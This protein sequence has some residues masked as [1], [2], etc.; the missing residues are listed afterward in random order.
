MIGLQRSVVEELLK[1]VKTSSIEGLRELLGKD[2]QG[3]QDIE[4]ILALGKNF[5]SC[6]PLQSYLTRF[7]IAESYGFRDWLVFDASVVRGLAYYTGVV[8]E[9]FD[10]SGQLRAI[11]GGGRYDKL[12]ESLGGESIPAVGFGFGDAVIVELLKMKNLLPDT[13]KN[14]VDSLVFASSVELQPI[15]SQVACELRAAG[16]KVDLVL[17]S[18]KTKWAFQRADKI[19]AKAVVMIAEDEW[20]NRKLIV[21]NLY[22]S[23]EAEKQTIC[24]V[25]EVSSVV[26]CIISKYV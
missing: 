22:T 14:E 4:R 21:K 7:S 1:C 12:L 15:A 3:L 20:K 19:G 13:S 23:D 6:L 24:A 16:V 10:R 17:E 2:T 11:C 8:F 5:L 9:G 18:K 26:S 25:E